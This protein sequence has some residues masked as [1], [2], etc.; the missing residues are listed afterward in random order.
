MLATTAFRVAALTVGVFLIAAAALSALL[1]WQ[2][3]RVVTQQVLDGLA[4][5]AA[6]LQ[7]QAGD[8]GLDALA[9]AV[10]LRSQP[11]GVGLYY[12]QGRGGEKLA[13]NLSRI[14]PELDGSGRGA[15]FNYDADGLGGGDAG[16]PG[17]GRRLAVALD[18]QVGSGRLIVGRDIDEQRRLMVDVRNIAIGG[19][20]LL[21]LCGLAAG[22]A[23]GWMVL[24]RVDAMTESSRAIMSGDLSQRL[25]QS[26]TGDELDRL[27]ASLNA[28]LERI[29]QL[30]NGMKEISD[31]I[32]HDLKTPVNRLRVRAE[33]ALRDPSG[34]PGY[35]AGLEKVIETADDII[36]TFNALLLIAR[37]ESGTL[38]DANEE[39]DAG[40]LLR[41]VVE[42]YEPVA[43]EAGLGIDASGVGLLRLSGN[44]QLIVQAV[45]NLID[46]AIKYSVQNV[47]AVSSDKGCVDCVTTKLAPV[48]VRLLAAHGFGEIVVGDHG[49]GIDA[50]DRERVL[51]RFIRLDK[52][53]SKPGTG[54]G[55]SLVCAVAR[56]HGG[57]VT[58]ADNNPGLRISLFLP[59]AAAPSGQSNRS[60]SS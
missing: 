26:G 6:V 29:E 53:R 38:E 17:G 18:I 14:P 57:K 10:S 35:R 9:K 15:V 32:A 33:A 36:K 27:A 2:M 39:F 31:N 16:R 59:L 48:E 37:L 50:A 52:S 45:A 58:L 3:N 5:E 43:E 24:R 21:A 12:L 30:M 56:L 23:I 40:E 28:M 41:D 54:L 51:K 20:G 11:S 34:E 46:N 7:R 60:A 44:R 4:G 47:E 8:D 22:L 42:L 55:L 13:G 19:F 1:F 49:P 25:P